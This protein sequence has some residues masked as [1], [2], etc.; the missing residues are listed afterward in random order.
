MSSLSI[1]FPGYADSEGFSRVDRGSK[2]YFVTEAGYFDALADSSS[3]LD[4]QY[5]DSPEHANFLRI[6]GSTPP[7][8]P[9]EPLSHL[10]SLEQILIGHGFQ[11]VTD[12]M[13]TLE[14]L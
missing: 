11:S 8:S 12:P 4:A 14:L 10:Q 1:S 6:F 3:I 13:I 7:L 5:F 2:V 9:S